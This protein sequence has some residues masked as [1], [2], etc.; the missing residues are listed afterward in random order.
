[1]LG[2]HRYYTYILAYIYDSTPFFPTA[3]TG[4]HQIWSQYLI[5]RVEPGVS[6]MLTDLLAGCLDLCSNPHRGNHTFMSPHT[7]TLSE[8]SLEQICDVTA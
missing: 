2:T 5:A 8:S 4:P 3:F 1:M 7:E 6:I